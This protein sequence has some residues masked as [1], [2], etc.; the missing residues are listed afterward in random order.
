MCGEATPTGAV[1]DEPID[2]QRLRAALIDRYRIQQEVGRGGM[3]GVYR[4]HD[5]K[6]DRP[7]AV[8]VMLPQLAATLGAQRFLRE[9]RIAAKLHHPHILALY[10]S[11]E[12]DGFLYHVMPYV[13]GESLRAR[14]RRDRQLP[15]DDALQI[16]REIAEALGYA[17]EAGVVHRDIKPEN[18][19]LSRDHALVADFGIAKAVSS[20]G[21]SA[22]TSTGISIGTPLYMS[23]EQAAGDPNVDHRAD[24]YS[25]GC[26]LYEMLAG[27]PPFTGP[28]AQA[29]LAK[30]AIESRPSVRIVRDTVPQAVDTAIQR[31]MARAPVD[32]FSDAGELAR[33]LTT[34]RSGAPVG[35]ERPSRTKSLRWYVVATITLVL[36]AVLLVPWWVG[37]SGT[38]TTSDTGTTL[39][40]FPFRALGRET[41]ELSE[42]LGDLLATALDGTRGLTVTDPWSLWRSLRPEPGAPA[43][44]PD[45]VEAAALAERAGANR[46]VLAS[47][48]AAGGQLQVSLRTYHVGQDEPHNTV[49]AAAPADSLLSFAQRLAV[50]VITVV[51]G[52]AATRS[53]PTLEQVSTGSVEA[54]KAYLEARESMR[55]GRVAEANTAIDRALALDSA[56]ALA[57]IE[58]PVIKSW[59][60]FIEGRPYPGL[61]D[62]AERAAARSDDL[63]ERNRLR[64]RAVL[65][66]IRTRGR[67]TAEAAASMIRLDSTDFDGWTLLAY[68]HR[69]YGWQYG[70]TV[71]AAVRASDRVVALDP[72]YIPGLVVRAGLAATLADTA[73]VRLQLERLRRA[74]TTRSLVRGTIR[75]LEL[76]LEPAEGFAVGVER[77][78][79]LPL[80]QWIA[81]YRLV[82]F[83]DP[84]GAERVAQ[85]FGQATLSTR[86]QRIAGAELLRLRLAQGRA[87]AV[88][89]AVVLGQLGNPTLER[90]IDRFLVAASVAGLVGGEDVRRSVQELADY[91][92]RDSALMLEDDRP[93]IET[94][95]ALASYSAVHGDTANA[96]RWAAVIAQLPPG[97]VQEDYRGALRA[98]IDA[99][100]ARRRGD[101]R[102]A[103]RL[104]GR[105]LELWSIHLDSQFDDHPE[106]A[107]RFHLAGLLRAAG[108]ADSAQALFRSLVPPTSWS[109]FYTPL[110]A[111]ALG[112][113]AAESGDRARAVEYLRIADAHWRRG[114][115][116]VAAWLTRTRESLERLGVDTSVRR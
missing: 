76:L 20:A 6:H 64:A 98:D 35:G 7:V 24:I 27:E 21:S 56:F 111:L 89:S 36:A 51:V 15:I 19:L 26:V 33:A 53:M 2:E 25:L 10:D 44:A 28:N 77:I 1:L 92:P 73:D 80:E 46:F 93:V 101:D 8:K 4:A 62:L 54:L 104:A 96:E 94:A 47:V 74:D 116:E 45:P 84:A 83:A 103:L 48:V 3:A 97:G 61:L 59:A 68:A 13:E 18:I 102:D 88:D 67:E 87:R 16:A 115:S 71:D 108:R 14:L 70:A 5:L 37:R 95:W 100:L 81:A 60:Q 105:A 72:T 29:I 43:R 23:P 78:T 31:A 113:M 66:S 58:A 69:A 79:A 9:I 65:A 85:A 42:A 55:R 75:G 82:R 112:E 86:S 63:S 38:S 34:T 106:I 22:L 107:M 50:E 114:G 39:A 40:V 11:G 91:V 110:A 12:A 57:L 90:T 49:T 41:T 109:G 99:R 52:A 30:H 17:H 32:R